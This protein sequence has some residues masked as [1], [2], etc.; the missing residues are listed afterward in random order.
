[1]TFDHNYGII[2]TG[3]E[4]KNMF[5]LQLIGSALIVGIV[6]YVGIYGSIIAVEENDIRKKQYRAG[7][8]D[9]YGNAIQNDQ[10][11]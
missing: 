5:I 1:L 6:G 8:H 10:D 7:T 4:E 3:I 9:Y 2:V 11:S